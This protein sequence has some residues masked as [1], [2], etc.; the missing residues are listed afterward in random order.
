MATTTSKGR[1][2]DPLKNLRRRRDI[3]TRQVGFDLALYDPAKTVMHLLNPVAAVIWHHVTPGRT[4]SNVVDALLLSFNKG[5]DN[6]KTITDDVVYAIDRLEQEGLLVRSNAET[7]PPAKTQPKTL[8]IPDREISGLTGY[9]R[10]SIKSFSVE[11]LNKLF[12]LNQ[13][14]VAPFSDL[15]LSGDWAVTN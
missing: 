8:A 7:P 13:S 6:A 14:T 15:A 2:K 12:A 11:E 1:G 4:L 5:D 9:A 3:R 10:P